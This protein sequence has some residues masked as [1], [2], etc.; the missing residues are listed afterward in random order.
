MPTDPSVADLA[1]R[2]HGGLLGA[3][4]GD[5]LGGPVEGLDA[6]EI[7]ARHGRVTT[8]LPYERESAEHGPWTLAAGSWTD[9]TRL[10]LMVAEAVISADGDVVAGDL[11]RVLVAR[12]HEGAHPLSL[13]AFSRSTS[14]PR[15][16][17]SASCCS[18]A[19]RP[20]GP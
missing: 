7:A 12:Y 8:M 1:E 4:C 13:K 3:A 14:A 15:C 19:T 18:A 20:T 6:D 16:T 17:A 5:A 9:D 10:S 2:V 11:A